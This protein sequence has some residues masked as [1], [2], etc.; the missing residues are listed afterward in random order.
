MASNNKQTTSSFTLS[1]LPAIVIGTVITL[2][3][4]G[5]VVYGPLGH[6]LLKRYVL[7][8]WVAE[9]S[10][11]MYCIAS[12][13]LALKWWVTKNQLKLT[14]DASS[15]LGELIGEA[16]EVPP[17]DRAAWLEASWGAQPALFC[18]SWFGQRLGQVVDLQLKRG[19]RSGVESDLRL[20]AE[21]DSDQQHDSYSLIRIITWAMPMLG[22]LGTVLGISETLGQLDTKLLATQSEQAMNQ[23]T[24][25]LYVA[26]D[27]TAVGLVL[28]VVAMF[29]QFT[30]SRAELKLL[31]QIDK[32]IQSN[33]L[34]FLGADPHDTQAGLLAP[35][36]MMADELMKSM[37]QL[38]EQQAK[39]WAKSMN[40]GH[41][42]WLEWTDKARNR[43]ETRLGESVSAALEQ[44]ATRLESV[45][46]E[47]AKQLD[48]RWQQWQVSLSEQ[49]RTIHSHQKEMIRQSDTLQRLVDSTCELR[50]IEDTIHLS[51]QRLEDVHR[52]E[53]A[54]M[55]IG[56]AVAMLA[57]SLERAGFIRGAP[58]KPRPTRKLKIAPEA[59]TEEGQRKAA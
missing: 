46:Q 45:Q 31:G 51:V 41:Q 33:L 16:G 26:F 1:L 23:L 54:S 14:T 37:G 27:T 29:T 35:M 9:A 53:E 10:V 20:L 36:R 17:S 25:G 13:H 47:A 39:L 19:N 48:A 58:V 28:T 59:S 55:C 56:E 22:F 43:V 52:L 4:Y 18:Q 38:V 21:T 7:C 8:H 42:Q 40:E 15:A 49:T 30:V 24:A 50:S 32:G 12:S 2:L 11:W 57:T 44:H 3:F 6:P 34:E 5:L